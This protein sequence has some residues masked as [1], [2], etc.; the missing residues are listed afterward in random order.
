MGD[1]EVWLGSSAATLSTCLKSH[2]VT[3]SLAAVL[4][5]MQMARDLLEGCLDGTHKMTRDLP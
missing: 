4:M 3:V 5:G 1:G 2:Q